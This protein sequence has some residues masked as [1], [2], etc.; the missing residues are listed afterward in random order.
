MRIFFS[1]KKFYHQKRQ[2]NG[3]RKLE[4]E[5]EWKKTFPYKRLVIFIDRSKEIR[6][7]QDARESS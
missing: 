4:N 7:S 1:F 6:G 2:R 5:A 3:G